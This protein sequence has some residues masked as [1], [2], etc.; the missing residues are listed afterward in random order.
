MGLAAARVVLHAQGNR[1]AGLGA[2]P[3]LIE[4]ETHEGLNEGALAARLLPDNEDSSGVEG[5][6]EILC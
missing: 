2:S 1:S 5:L 4:L 6:L 3:N